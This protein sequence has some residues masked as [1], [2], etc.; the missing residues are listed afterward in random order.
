LAQCE[1]LNHTTLGGLKIAQFL[2]ATRQVGSSTHTLE[3]YI[4]NP[5]FIFVLPSKIFVW[6][7]YIWRQYSDWLWELEQGHA[8]EAFHANDES[9]VE[10]TNP[11][12]I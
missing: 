4:E 2:V 9:G 6:G 10:K 8:D 1:Y 12:A 5:D 3:K 11:Q 7:A